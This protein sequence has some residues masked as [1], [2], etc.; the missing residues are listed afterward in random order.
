MTDVSKHIDAMKRQYD[1]TVHVEEI[2]SLIRGEWT[3]LDLTNYGDLVLEVR[4]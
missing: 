2:Q 3:G 1:M 4:R